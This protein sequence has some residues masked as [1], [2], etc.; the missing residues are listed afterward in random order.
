VIAFGGGALAA[1]SG[2]S[3][4]GRFVS[5]LSV[6]GQWAVQILHQPYITPDIV[7]GARYAFAALALGFLVRTWLGADWIEGVGWSMIALLLALT[8]VMPWYVI[9]VLPFAALQAN[10][11]L[12]NSALAIFA[13][14]LIIRLPLTGF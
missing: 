11:N 7:H 9:W 2:F 13:F 8:W 6:P 14:L 12:R 3:G 5:S 10:R 1:L 4:Q